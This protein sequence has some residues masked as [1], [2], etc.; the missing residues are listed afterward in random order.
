MKRLLITFALLTP[1]LVNAASFDCQK[2]KAADEKTICAHLALN[3]KDV[4][5]HTNYQF[6]KGLFAMGSRGALQDAQRS[7]LKQRQQ[8]KTDAAC[9]TK[10]YNERLKQLDA[11]YDHIDKPL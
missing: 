4:E 7:W 6:L 5:M 9:L 8:C 11:L 1:L 3:D 2:A 10:A